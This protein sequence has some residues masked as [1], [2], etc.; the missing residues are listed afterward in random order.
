[1][2][3]IVCVDDRYGM[4]FNHRRQ[5]QDAKV[6]ED[7]LQIVGNGKLFVSP[8]T[9]GQFAE[10]EQEKLYISEEFLREAGAAEYC[11][12]EAADCLKE[13]AEP[14]MIILYGWNRR[15]PADSYFELNLEEYTL[16]S[17]NYLV[18]ISHPEIWK[19][20]YKR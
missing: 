10:T 2:K 7:M 1:M 16:A 12:A 3:L 15:Y 20:V 19:K 8:Y 4:M 11:F 9:A 18:G 17:W 6:R 5:S 14:E 13:V